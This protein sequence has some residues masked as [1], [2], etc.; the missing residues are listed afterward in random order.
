MLS[1]MVWAGACH[2]RS[3]TIGG[4]T[5]T[6]A[7]TIQPGTDVSVAT[8]PAAHTTRTQTLAIV[9][10]M[11]S[12]FMIPLYSTAASRRCSTVHSAPGLLLIVARCSS[13]R[14]TRSPLSTR[15]AVRAF[16]SGLCGFEH[17]QDGR[18]RTIPI[19]C[20]PEFVTRRSSMRFQV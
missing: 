8:K 18:G 20:T 4:S 12:G 15:F 1:D 16:E 13:R 3:M 19:D 2:N 14:A 9:T 5:A 6:Q 11:Y 10:F 17:L 7:S